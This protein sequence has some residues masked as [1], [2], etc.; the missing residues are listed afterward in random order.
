M[1]WRLV[2]QMKLVWWKEQE[3]EQAQEQE[4]EQRSNHQRLL[5]PQAWHRPLLQ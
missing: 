4:Q 1:F 5:Q 2:Q 3:Q